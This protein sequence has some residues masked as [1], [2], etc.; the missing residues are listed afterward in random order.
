VVP[1]VDRNHCV[2]FSRRARS[3]AAALAGSAI[4]ARGAGPLPKRLLTAPLPRCEAPEEEAEA[5]TA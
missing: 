3:A 5:S 1:D 2:S 4:P